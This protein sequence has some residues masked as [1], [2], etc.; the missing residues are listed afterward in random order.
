MLILSYVGEQVLDGSFWYFVTKNR[1]TGLPIPPGLQVYI[2][3]YTSTY[4]HE[5]Y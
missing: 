1:E 2:C 3:I 4:M 5:Y